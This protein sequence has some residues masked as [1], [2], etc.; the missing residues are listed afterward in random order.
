VSSTA[1]LGTS[2]KHATGGGARRCTAPPER[3]TSRCSPFSSVWPEKKIGWLRDP[4]HA[5]RDRR[6]GTAR[7]YPRRGH[8]CGGDAHDGQ[9]PPRRCSWLSRCAGTTLHGSSTRGTISCRTP[10]RWD[11]MRRTPQFFVAKV[12]NI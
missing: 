8:A 2:W 11:K 3:A 7:G 1:R 12:D 10:D 4:G 5:K 6:D 9:P